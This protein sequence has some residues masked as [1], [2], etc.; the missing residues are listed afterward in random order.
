ME[1]DGMVRWLCRVG[2]DSSPNSHYYLRGA[3]DQGGKGAIGLI[4]HLPTK[5]NLEY[6]A[7]AK[8]KAVKSISELDGE[9]VVSNSKRMDLTV[10]LLMLLNKN[11]FIVLT[12]PF[13]FATTCLELDVAM[14]RSNVSVIQSP[15]GGYVPWINEQFIYDN[16][17][18]YFLKQVGQSPIERRPIFNTT[19]V[20]RCKYR[21]QN[22]A[23]VSL[24]L[25]ILFNCPRVDNHS[26][27]LKLLMDVKEMV[28]LVPLT[29]N[30]TITK[31]VAVFFRTDKCD[32]LGRYLVE[33]NMSTPPQF[34]IT[35]DPFGFF[36]G[37]LRKR[38]G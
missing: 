9:T 8:K 38:A 37:T 30:M 20:E 5:Q 33:E 31:A 11:C 22:G 15:T 19:S 6:V 7:P 29:S 18:Q 21:T 3:S 36:D 14:L 12:D 13:N 24:M 34:C 27:S 10:D 16:E 28:I 26:W 35:T 17:D 32:V 4:V 2:F 1:D 25:R 23:M